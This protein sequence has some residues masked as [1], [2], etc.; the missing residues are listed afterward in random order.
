MVL[1]GNRRFRA[2]AYQILFVGVI[3]ALLVAG[4]IVTYH[5]L[6]AQGITSGFDF[7]WRSTGWNIGVALLPAAA[8]DPYWYVILLGFLNTLFAGLL[9]LLFATMVGAVVGLGR[10]SENIPARTLAAIYVEIFRNTPLILQ[11]FFWYA[12][13][14]LLPPQAQSL[15]LAGIYLNNRGLFVPG[16]NVSGISVALFYLALVATAIAFLWIAYARRFRRMDEA[17]KRMLLLAVPLAGALCAFAFLWIGHTA[18]EPL[19]SW[20]TRRGLNFAGGYRVQPE[21]YILIFAIAVYGGAYIAEIV[22]G[23]FLAVG[24]GQT[25]A[26]RALGLSPWQS[27]SR[28]RLPLALRSMLP[29]LSNQYIWLIKAT[30]LGT[31]VGFSDIFLVIATGITQSGQT[32]EFIAILMG[33]FLVINLTLA[34][35]LNHVN[36]AIA[37]KGHQL[38]T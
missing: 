1:L 17:R 16:F 5:N 7:L 19:M 4:A 12:L 23:G 18:G 15:Q 28:I 14:S 27:F 38:R 13:S 30:T 35:A 20:P 3:V 21:V 36:R 26:A 31:V 8:T 29:I 6:K 11:L 9:G 10:I 22:R 34:R 24:R 37:L 2:L 25:E 32:L 33:G